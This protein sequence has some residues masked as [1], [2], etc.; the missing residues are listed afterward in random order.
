MKSKRHFYFAN[1]KKSVVSYG[2]TYKSATV[3]N[4]C[5]INNK[6]IDYVIDTTKNKQNKYTPGSHLKIYSPEKQPLKKV[7]YYF[8][9]AWNFKKEILTKE[10]KFLKKGGKFIS[11]VPKVKILK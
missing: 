9:G 8:L 5:K 4:Y 3:F 2:A 7:D 11:H 1:E 10:K 6:L